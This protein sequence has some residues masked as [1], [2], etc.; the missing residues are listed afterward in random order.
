MKRYEICVL[1]C[2]IDR[3]IKPDKPS[4]PVSNVW[5]R[6]II[7]IHQYG[8]DMLIVELAGIV[9]ISLQNAFC[10]RFS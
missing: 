2:L 9:E 4:Q 1:Y 3:K 10:F 7:T 6:R 5:Y 8:N